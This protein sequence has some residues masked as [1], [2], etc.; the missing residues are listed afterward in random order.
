MTENRLN[1]AHAVNRRTT[2]H[3]R[4][5]ATMIGRLTA[6]EFDLLDA[7][8]VNRRAADRRLVTLPDVRRTLGGVA[9]TTDRKMLQARSLGLVRREK[10]GTMIDTHGHP[11]PVYGFELTGIGRH[12]FREAL[13][14]LD[15]RAGAA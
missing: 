10:T 11:H 7:I 13:R 14:V 4:N 6:R 5:N 8:E 9:D 2:Y 3:P 1:P 15:E 12:L